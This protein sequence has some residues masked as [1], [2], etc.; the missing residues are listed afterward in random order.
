MNHF[1]KKRYLGRQPSKEFGAYLRELREHNTQLNQAEAARQI[2]IKPEQLNYFEQ[3]TRAPPDT[4]L[5][6][7]ARLYHV[8][9]EEIL[10]RAYW[11]QLI[12]LPL[13]SIINPEQL[14][15]E[16][17][18]EIEKGLEEAERQELTQFIERLLHRRAASLK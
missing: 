4:I 6:K 13:I 1:R 11:P 18:E 16:L 8:P 3:G 7:L 9:P 12:L 10:A 17:I 2:E 14:S 5:I 15:K